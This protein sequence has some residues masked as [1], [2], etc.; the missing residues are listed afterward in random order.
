MI[1]ASISFSNGAEQFDDKCAP[2]IVEYL[3]SKGKLSINVPLNNT[4]TSSQCP[5]TIAELLDFGLADLEMI[6][7]EKLADKSGCVV[8]EFKRMKELM[9]FFLAIAITQEIDSISEKD[10]NTQLNSSRSALKP[11]LKQTAVKCGV[12]EGKFFSAFQ[13]E[14]VD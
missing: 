7:E 14:L 2:T 13:K 11:T 6:M 10:R 9:E 4:E 5:Y 3:K 8:M 1:Y 12:E